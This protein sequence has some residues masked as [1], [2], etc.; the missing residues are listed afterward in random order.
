MADGN[1]D[2]PAG[3]RGIWLQTKSCCH[4]CLGAGN[5]KSN[6]G[7]TQ[8]GKKELK[9]GSKLGNKFQSFLQTGSVFDSKTSKSNHCHSGKGLRHE[10]KNV[11]FLSEG[12]GKK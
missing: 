12:L 5:R 1:V 7:Q 11:F 10:T 2:L 4:E 6:Q 8:E 9:W 3:K